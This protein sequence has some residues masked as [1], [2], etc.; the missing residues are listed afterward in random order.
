MSA[1]VATNDVWQFAMLAELNAFQT[2]GANSRD[3]VSC[4][5]DQGE[6]H[7][8]GGC[9]KLCNWS[10]SL[11]ICFVHAED[12]LEALIAQLSNLHSV[13]SPRK[14]DPLDKLTF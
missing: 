14:T 4:M 9:I 3:I 2:S 10:L 6:S 1:L 13:P 5:G 12:L 7:C 8:F 11:P